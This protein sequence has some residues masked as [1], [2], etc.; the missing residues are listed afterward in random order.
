L[1]NCPRLT[2]LS[3]TG[4]Q[5]FLRD[6]LTVFCREAPA[7]FNEHQRE[8]FCVFSGNGVAR[9]R[10]YL[11]GA[12]GPGV[13][14]SMGNDSDD[15]NDGATLR[16]HP[17]LPPPPP[18]HHQNNYTILHTWHNP[19]FHH[20]DIEDEDMDDDGDGDGAETPNDGVGV[21]VGTLD[22]SVA[23]AA[24]NLVFDLDAQS[25]LDGPAQ[26]DG[27]SVVVGGGAGGG[28]GGGALWAGGS[29]E[30]QHV[31]GMMS[32]AILDDVD[33]DDDTTQ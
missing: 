9:L 17:L 7:E 29:G 27:V 3:L 22:A 21:G 5:A 6:D 10:E 23:A 16:N 18:A 13:E 28:S 15:D 20:Q 14:T 2:H 8:V 33:D 26:H 12:S 24:H 19:E 25:L 32:A 30:A 31:I 11:N 4:V 1:N